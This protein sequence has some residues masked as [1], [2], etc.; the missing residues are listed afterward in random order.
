MGKTSFFNR[1]LSWLSFNERL[2]IEAGRDN[3]P[4]LERLKFLSIFSSN[5]DEFYRVRIPALAA[6]SKLKAEKK[7]NPEG[8]AENARILNQ[9]IS[10]IDNQQQRYGSILKEQLIPAL[11]EKN[12]HLVYNEALPDQVLSAARKHFYNVLAGCIRICFLKDNKDFVPE[13]NRLYLAVVLERKDKEEIALVNIPSELTSRFFI[14]QHE[15]TSYIVFI[16]DIIREMLPYLFDRYK[17]NGSYAIKIT[18]DAEL[19]LLDEFE[20]DLAEKIEKQITKRDFGL[21]TR[22]LH[23]P[24][25]PPQVIE[26]L[27]ESFL[28]T[29]ANIIAGG[30][31]HNLKDLA[32]I[33][34]L[35]PDL[36]Y[37]KVHALPFK[38]ADADRTLFEEIADRDILINAP[39]Q[40]YATVLRFFNE[41]AVDNEVDEIFTTLYRV[42]SDSRIAHALISAAIN[43]KKVTVFVELK[44]RFDESNNIKWA[45]RMKEAGIKVIYSI[46][47]LK[48]HAKVALIKRKQNGRFQYLGLLATGNL[49]ESTAKFYTDHILLTAH[50]DILHELELVFL[51]LGL[52]KKADPDYRIPF[53]H[54]LVAQFNL[55]QKF[56][57]LIDKEIANAKK[58]NAAGITIKLNNLE[59]Q[60]LIRKLYEASNA[61]VKINLIIR[62]IC[63]L[64]PGVTGISENIS[65][66]R[67]VD[68]YL[69]HGRI[70]IF[71]NNN[72]ELIYLGSSDWMDRNIYR[73]IE[74]CF[75]LYD[76]R[77]KEQIKTI[78][79]LQLNDD[80]AAVVLDQQLQNKAI[81]PS[82][83]PVRSQE[84]IYDFL[85]TQGNAEAEII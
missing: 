16:D 34:T 30:N 25:L 55:Q 73:R 22:F 65:V 68:K 41:A 62:G 19:D 27:S 10:I 36:V 9:V 63:C 79:Q 2:L 3:V 5:L 7:K 80:V 29:H 49:N 37:P 72:E 84:A 4:L 31:Y 59:E 81:I 54:L 77:L 71:T 6:F 52:R 56:L 67:I 78:I 47:G 48:V 66:R 83:N 1:D 17:I 32:M 64:V 43:G 35:S 15:Q 85:K 42:A 53:E 24:G 60:V 76:P 70:F 21:A 44:A 28:L 50:A 69:E 13:N 51:F 75:P 23:Q 58:G 74:V 14:Y 39:Y 61:G 11:K 12:I 57:E 38:F 45:K 20:G 26:K 33:P 8:V 46:P 82:E 18:R 40:S